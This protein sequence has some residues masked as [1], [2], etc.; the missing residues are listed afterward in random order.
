ML[1]HGAILKSSVNSDAKIEYTLCYLYTNHPSTQ[2]T[3]RNIRVQK[4]HVF[5]YTCLP[6][7]LK[8]LSFG[9]S[10]WPEDETIHTSLSV[11]AKYFYSS[12]I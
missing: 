11:L 8:G 6:R 10:H 7:I 1:N 2:S 3:V 5:V 4:D 9:K 12:Y